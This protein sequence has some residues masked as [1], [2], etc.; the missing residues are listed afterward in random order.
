MIIFYAQ[1]ETANTYTCPGT[2]KANTPGMFLGSKKTLALYRADPEST[3][4]KK[5][6][7]TVNQSTLIQALFVI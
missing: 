6:F 3:F 2:A 4:A 5:M 1:I 7:H